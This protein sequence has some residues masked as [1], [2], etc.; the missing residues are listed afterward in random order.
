MHWG[1]WNTHFGVYFHQG[2]RTWHEDKAQS[3]SFYLEC[4]ILTHYSSIIQK[5]TAWSRRKKLLTKLKYSLNVHFLTK[6]WKIWSLKWRKKKEQQYSITAFLVHCNVCQSAHHGGIKENHTAQRGRS[7]LQII[8]KVTFKY[9]LIFKKKKRKKKKYTSVCLPP[10]LR[11]RAMWNQRKTG[12]IKSA[13]FILPPPGQ[14]T[15]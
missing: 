11:C 9:L 2:V 5:L 1:A 15:R 10:S 6:M 4:Q 8:S 13:S 12:G 3:I 7:N 14:L